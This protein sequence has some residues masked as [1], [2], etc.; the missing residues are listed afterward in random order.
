M[1]FVLL[2]CLEV[3]ENL[4]DISKFKQIKMQ[5]TTHNLMQYPSRLNQWCNNVCNFNGVIMF[6]EAS[7]SFQQLYHH[8][9]GSF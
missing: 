3:T 6:P 8:V 7:F 2:Q 5:H 9:S 1:R 4:M